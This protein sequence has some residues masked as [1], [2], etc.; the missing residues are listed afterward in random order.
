MKEH[1]RN[2]AKCNPWIIGGLVGA[3]SPL[4]TVIYGA[5]QRSW[6]LALAPLLPLIIWA[7]VF[8]DSSD[9]SSKY[10]FQAIAG[11]GA[12]AIAAINRKETTEEEAL[13]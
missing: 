2:R 3:V 6:T 7:I 5:R 9:K 1:I 10:V 13:Q 8:I 4:I 11:V 12:G